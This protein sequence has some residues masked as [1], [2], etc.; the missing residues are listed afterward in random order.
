MKK[1][2]L[3]LVVS[4]LTLSQSFGQFKLPKKEDWI[5]ASQLPLVVVLKEKNLKTVEKLTNNGKTE[6]LELYIAYIDDYNTYI[7]KYVEIYWDKALIHAY[8]TESEFKNFEGDKKNKKKYTFITSKYNNNSSKA[9][10]KAHANGVFSS[11][12]NFTNNTQISFGIIG[13]KFP[14]TDN[15]LAM[16]FFPDVNQGFFKN[17]KKHSFRESDLKF[18]VKYFKNYMNEITTTDTN[19][20][21][22]SNKEKVAYMNR[23]AK[24]L[25]QLTLLVD[26]DLVSES[27]LKE[28]KKKYK[29]KYELVDAERVENAI[30]NNEEGYAYFHNHFQPGMNGTNYNLLYVY[31]TKD[32]TMLYFT[33]PKGQSGFKL[34]VFTVRPGSKINDVDELI[35][36]IGN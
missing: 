33:Y 5:L 32:L 17:S 11:N 21:K 6:E 15:A 7:K 16:Q 4:L 22:M 9:H 19:L 3:L 18:C 26:K 10:R 13:E 23:N 20:D 1:T 29:F 14:M 12:A 31:E 2:I 24:E 8:M 36:A 34:G 35:E 30:L 28:F 27:F 25:K